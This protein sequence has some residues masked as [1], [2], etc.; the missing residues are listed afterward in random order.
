MVNRI[1]PL[2]AAALVASLL[3]FL[4]S[5]PGA[6]EDAAKKPAYVGAKSCKKCHFQQSKSWKKTNLALAFEHLKPGQCDEEK[7]ACGLDPKKDY[8]TDPKCLKCHATGYGTES[9]YPTVTEGKAFTEEQKAQAA[10]NEGVTC[11]A[12]HGLGSL[13]GPYKKEHK[14]Y[15]L[16]DIVKLGATA[17]VTAA[18]CEPCH[19]KE[20]PTMPDDYKFDFEELKTS[21]KLHK[22]KK[23]KSE[24]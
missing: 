7:K 19:V 12:C 20:C 4:V 23:L 3:M 15:K 8:T 18:L 22:H 24:H 13:Y 2:V 6:A 9:G 14:D 1:T 11:E 21:D 10:L 17:P 5:S 16:A